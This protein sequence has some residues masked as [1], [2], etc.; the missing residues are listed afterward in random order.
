MDGYLKMFG[1]CFITNGAARSLIYDAQRKTY[2]L[3]PHALVRF[4]EQASAKPY[5]AVKASY[6]A[7]DRR[8]L[9]EYVDFLLEHDIIF[10]CGTLEELD[11][12]PPTDT[13]WEY[14]AV[15]TNAVIEAATPERIHQFN[16]ARGDLFIPYLQLN[17]TAPVRQIADLELLVT[18]ASQKPVK[19]VQLFFSNDAGFSEAALIELCNRAKIIETL[20]AFNSSF[21]KLFRSE[22]THLHFTRQANHDQQACGVVSPEYFNTEWQHYTESLKYNTCLNRKIAV[23]E[24]GAIKNCP[25]MHRSYG[26]IGTT[27]LLSVINNPDFKEMWHIKKDQIRVCKDCE[28]RHICTDCRAYLETPEDPYS[29]PLKCGYDPY[30]CEWLSWS[31]NPLK[32][33]A[34]A[35]YKILL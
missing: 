25:A 11:R 23:D 7:A 13:H 21:E 2:Y 22:T 29:Q 14:P 33:K 31:A 15:I 10:F 18:I 30:T 19:G 34:A 4:L 28:F 20:V 6:P 16:E 27:S 5:T 17:V 12:F 3:V 35:H 24:N 9:E 26:H 8:F 1:N 32:E